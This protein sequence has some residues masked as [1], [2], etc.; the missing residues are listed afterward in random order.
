MARNL[1]RVA[2][3]AHRIGPVQPGLVFRFNVPGEHY[4]DGLAREFE[5]PANSVCSKSEP[6][7]L[8]HPHAVYM[9]KE[10]AVRAGIM[11]IENPRK[12]AGRRVR[13]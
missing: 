8:V 2:L 6:S 1:T 12:S 5:V 11:G 9:H 10:D 7:F 13:R 4:P 3:P